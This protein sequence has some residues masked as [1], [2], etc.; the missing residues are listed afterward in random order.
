MRNL[1]IGMGKRERHGLSCQEAT[2]V[3]SDKG[4]YRKRR[5]KT[6]TP[7]GCFGNCSSS[8]TLGAMI[9]VWR[10]VFQVQVMIIE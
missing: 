10:G 5:G 7:H 1:T 8:I 3:D 2:G 6:F 9:Q 4:P